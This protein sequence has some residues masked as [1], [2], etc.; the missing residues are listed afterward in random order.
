M[1]IRCYATTTISNLLCALA[2]ILVFV[3]PISATQADERQVAFLGVWILNDELSDDPRPRLGMTGSD[4]ERGRRGRGGWFGPSGGG[5]GGRGLGG[6]RG[7]DGDRSGPEEMAE[8]RAALQDAMRDLMTAARRITIVGTRDEILL[9]YNDGRVVRLLPD[10]REHAGVAGTSMRV[11]RTTRWDDK[12]LVTDIELKGRV[13]FEIERSY[14]V[15][16]G[17]SGRQ[18]IIISRFA[19]EPFGGE[20]REFRRIY[21]AENPSR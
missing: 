12:I 8:R 11:A 16:N 1:H 5:F 7:H 15:R 20:K 17:E 9:T 2:G 4:G 13:K 6:R 19:G 10:G 3:L 21:N 14:E 18:L